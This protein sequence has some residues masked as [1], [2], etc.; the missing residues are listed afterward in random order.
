MIVDDNAEMGD[1]VTGIGGRYWSQTMT[2]GGGRYCGCAR[3]RLDDVCSAYSDTNNS[4]G[5][6]DRKT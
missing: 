2:G 3:F 4:F 6:Y 1:A 5:C